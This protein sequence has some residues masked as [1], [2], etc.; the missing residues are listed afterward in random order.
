MRQAK[1]RKQL[2]AKMNQK[3][4]P[5]PKAMPALPAPAGD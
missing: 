5:A 3:L 1:F 4:L 2:E